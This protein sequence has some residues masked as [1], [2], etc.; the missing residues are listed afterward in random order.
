MALTN[1]ISSYLKTQLINHILRNIPYT[2]PNDVYLALYTSDGNQEIYGSGYSRVPCPTFTITEDVATNSET[3]YF[4]M[5][6]STWGDITE[7]ITHFGVLDSISGGNLLFFGEL[8]DAAG[9]SASPIKISTN[10]TLRIDAGNLSIAFSG[11][12]DGG[13]GIST[14]SNLLDGVLNNELLD[15]PGNT[16]YLGLGWS[17]VNNLYYNFSSWLE[18]TASDYSRKQI[19][20]TD[21]WDYPILYTPIN[22]NTTISTAVNRN[23]IL[24]TEAA[25]SNWGNIANTALFNSSSGGDVLLWGTLDSITTILKGD[26]FRFPFNKIHA[27]ME[28]LV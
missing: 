11:D 7:L 3:I 12:E 18:V 17:L 21:G 1:I 14:A 9:T 16:V 23:E 5:A 26:G 24:F 22:S 15:F 2:P 6:T 19:A 13:W 4:P 10:N 20:G 27:A 28:T 8:T 25:G